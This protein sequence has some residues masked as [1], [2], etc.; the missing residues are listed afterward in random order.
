MADVR[1]LLLPS[2]PKIQKLID[3]LGWKSCLG[4]STEIREFAARVLAEIASDIH[5]VQFPGAIQCISSLLEDEIITKTCSNGQQEQ[6]RIKRYEEHDSDDNDDMDDA[7]DGSSGGN[8]LILQALTILERLASHQHNCREIFSTPGLVPKIVAPLYTDTLIQDISDSE[9]WA[10]IVNRCF[11]VVNRLIHAPG[12][13]GQSLAMKLA[14]RQELQ[15]QAVLILAEL[16]LDMSI[17][18]PTETKENFIKKQLEIFLADE[19][20]PPT[21]LKLKAN[22]GA[23]LALLSANSK[24]N[25]AI[26]M[27]E[28]DD[29]VARLTEMLEAKNNILHRTKAA[30]IIGNL[31]AQCVLDK[32]HVTE[33]LLP[34]VLTE[35]LSTKTKPTQDENFLPRKDEENQ[36]TFAH[37]GIKRLCR[38]PSE[39]NAPKA[40]LE[41]FL[42]LTLVIYDKV[43]SADDFHVV[44]QKNTRKHI[45]VVTIKD[46]VIDNCQET[47]E[48]LR[49]VKLCSHIAVSMIRRSRY[50]E[51]FRNQEF[52]KALSEAKAALSKLESR[53]LF[54]G[55]DLG[56][57][58]A[59][60]LL[61]ALEKEAQAL[62]S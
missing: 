38:Q 47:A 58:T 30:E 57:N 25:S 44:L 62:V 15:V 53:M 42:S 43:I 22:A 56:K 16:A 11:K 31:C 12:E 37:G 29:V 48:S 21:M 32:Q 49:I 3:T 33:T 8:E 14:R 36:K 24:D 51:E 35:I 23:T 19:A 54:A 9:A 40:L 17:N 41:A 27:K 39:D 61:S 2:R 10:D 59:R 13:T 18:L 28:H 46:I 50:A 52:M 6:Q 60:P 4:N 26:I 5:L 34:L 55:A 7:M 20:P 1:P 45:F